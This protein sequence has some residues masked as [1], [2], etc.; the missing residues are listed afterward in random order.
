MHGRPG[1]VFKIPSTVRIFVCTEP[2]D[3]AQALFIY[4]NRCGRQLRVRCFSASRLPAP[5]S[6]LK[7]GQDPRIRWQIRDATHTVIV[8]PAR[9]R[10]CAARNLR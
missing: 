4:T 8:R 5:R 6:I 10:A 2:Q 9:L 3:A 1:G 7:L